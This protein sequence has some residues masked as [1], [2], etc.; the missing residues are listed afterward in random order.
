LNG[1]GGGLA[2]Y[3]FSVGSTN[4]ERHMT[5]GP[6]IVTHG[7]RIYADDDSGHPAE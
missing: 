7:E 5:T 3:F 4:L 6:E 1:Y 2:P